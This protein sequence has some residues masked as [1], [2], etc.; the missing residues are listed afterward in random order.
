[1]RNI[2]EIQNVSSGQRQWIIRMAII[3]FLLALSI[4]VLFSNCQSGEGNKSEP[5]VQTESTASAL[6][7][8]Q[9]VHL[10][11]TDYVHIAGHHSAE[12][13]NQLK[14]LESK[15]FE[16]GTLAHQLLDYLKSGVNDFGEEFKF[17]DLRFVD[18]TAELN[19]KFSH[20]ISDLAALMNAFPNLKVKIMSHT[21]NV[22]GEKANEILSAKR[23]EIIKS[24]LASHGIADD[25]VET[26]AFGQKF[27]VGDNKIHEGRLI[28]N[29]IEL[30]V[31]SK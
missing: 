13:K 25:R 31:L 3:Q 8:G 21:D 11:D 22:G 4:L 20:E 28:N 24:E 18:R 7:S 9:Q 15:N 26:K 12:A 5:G 2:M 29:R 1:M 19:P 30:M 6:D 10:V 14:A 17:I 16:K 27:P 23:V